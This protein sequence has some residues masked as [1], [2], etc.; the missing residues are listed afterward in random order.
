VF[1][2][3]CVCE[4]KVSFFFRLR[5]VNILRSYYLFNC[6]IFRLYDYLH[7]EIYLLELV[8][9]TTDVGH[10]PTLRRI[11]Q[12]AVNLRARSFKVQK[13][14]SNY[15]ICKSQNYGKGMS[16]KAVEPIN[17]C[18]SIRNDARMEIGAMIKLASQHS[19]SSWSACA[20]H[21]VQFP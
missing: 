21:E 5:N 12:I 11:Y 7:A 3:C 1:A 4:I 17:K 6:Y 13:A 16:L 8:L 15:L 2:S 20:G 10:R 18:K 9:L 14:Q 19:R